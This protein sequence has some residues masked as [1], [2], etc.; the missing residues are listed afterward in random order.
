MLVKLSGERYISTEHI[1]SIEP[2]S[3]ANSTSAIK[4]SV[5]M[6]SGDMIRLTQTQFEELMYALPAPYDAESKRRNSKAK[7]S[8]LTRI[9]T[10]AWTR[11][12]EDEQA[13]A[14]SAEVN[15]AA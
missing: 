4:W 15:R 5:R 13:D 7:Q 10:L 6:G 9:G 2:Y 11:L 12:T 1:E 3:G 14:I 8:V